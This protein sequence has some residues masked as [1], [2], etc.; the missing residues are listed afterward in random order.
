ML[1]SILGKIAIGFIVIAYLLT[2]APKDKQ[3][4][5]LKRLGIED[6]WADSTFIVWF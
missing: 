4:S 1:K 3:P 2:S 6:V 5:N